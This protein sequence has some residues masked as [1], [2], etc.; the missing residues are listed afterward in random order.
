MPI[1]RFPNLGGGAVTET[2]PLAVKLADVEN[3]VSAS[4]SKVPTSGLLKSIKEGLESSLSTLTTTVGLKALASD[5][6]ISLGLKADKADTYTKTQIDTTVSGLNTTIS[7]KEPSI[8]S[9]TTAQYIK[10]DKTLGTMDKSAVGLGNVDNTSDANKPVSTAQLTALNLKQDKYSFTS[11]ATAGATTTLTNASTKRIVFTGVANQTCVLPN[12]TTS[13]LGDWHLVVNDSTGTVTVQSSGLNT[14]VTLATL[15]SALIH[16]TAI[17]GTGIASWT[18]NIATKSVAGGL[19]NWTESNNLYSTK[20]NVKYT[21]NSAQTNVDAVVQPKG[22]GAFYLGPQADGT[23]T[24]G[25]NRGNYA[26]DLQMQREATSQVASGSN[27]LVAGFD[28]TAT[29]SFG[30]ALGNGNSANAQ[31]AVG[32]G[33]ANILT[34]NYG[35][36][37]GYGNQS[38]YDVGAMIGYSCVSAGNYSLTTGQFTRNDADSSFVVGRYT[39][40]RYMCSISFGHYG[41]LGKRQNHLL[42]A[43]AVT[44]STTAVEAFTGSG[45]E[46]ILLQINSTLAFKIIAI[47]TNN[48][49]SCKLVRSGIITKLTTAGSTTISTIVTDD[50]DVAVGSCLGAITIT[51][52]TTNGSL[53]ISVNSGETATL[54]WAFQIQLTEV[55]A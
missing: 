19:T 25:N 54:N 55:T 53:K 34:G 1:K 22:N 35:F 11:I 33:V 51:A 26:V 4:T 21:P 36:G 23:V 50:T 5:V 45:S 44:T 12:V 9:G 28:N 14:L 40:S 24:G 18:Y 52:D 47:G 8:T 41:T 32:L 3:T 2:D 31:G 16:C 48:T 38:G 39:N 15:Q 10:G 42:S 43:N 49:K 7:G 46:R 17:T 30:I 20:Y 13:V 27:S 6:A 29:G 37:A